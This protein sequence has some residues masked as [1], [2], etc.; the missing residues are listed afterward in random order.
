MSDY[1]ALLEIERFKELTE[2]AAP[3][4]PQFSA[5]GRPPQF[6]DM[7]LMGLEGSFVTPDVWFM[8]MAKQDADMPRWWSRR[9]DWALRDYMRSGDGMT[10][11]AIAGEVTRVKNMPWKLENAAGNK[12][13]LAFYQHIFNNANF[14][15]G[16]D[17]LL[18]NVAYDAMCADNGF[19]IE[20]IPNREKRER[21]E[22]ATE[23]FPTGGEVAL[24]IEKIELAGIASMDSRQCWR[25]FSPEWPVI[26]V[27]PWT[28]KY[29]IYHW[30]RIISRSQFT[31]PDELGRKI[32]F[33]ALSRIF[34]AARF[35]HAM[36]TYYYEKVTGGGSAIGMLRNMTTDQM[37]TALRG[38]NLDLGQNGNDVY[39]GIMWIGGLNPDAE[40]DVKLFSPRSLP[41]GFEHKEEWEMAAQIIALG[42]GVAVNEIISL[43]SGG[44][45]QSKGEAEI[46]H[47]NAS[48]KGREDILNLIANPLNNR[49][50]SEETTFTF[51]Q[52]D[53]QEDERKARIKQIRVSTRSQQV[54]SGELMAEEARIM[55]AEAG[56]YKCR[57]FAK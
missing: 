36:T 41:D 28:G 8:G 43:S 31:Q 38:G 29:T 30:T 56:G 46:Q 9:R 47:G 19:F 7:N 20:L 23:M 37:K 18:N 12:E 52:K 4:S 39:P 6:E 16:F 13:E 27:N 54:M 11:G 26:Y 1:D 14:G 55:A 10:I 50:L 25:T 15:D 21:I 57:V 49:A 48:R 40:V 5:A 24:P 44:L 17:A 2:G 32:G 53:D 51:D 3:N 34:F 42:L 22:G 45:G 35:L 33:C